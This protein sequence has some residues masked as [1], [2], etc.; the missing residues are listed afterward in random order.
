MTFIDFTYPGNYFDLTDILIDTSS[1]S[2]AV[3]VCKYL[4]SE[5][6]AVNDKLIILNPAA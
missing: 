3:Q 6:L 1:A 4:K 5:F 2:V